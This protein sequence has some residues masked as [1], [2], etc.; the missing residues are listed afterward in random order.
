MESRTIPPPQAS[1]RQTE[2]GDAFDRVLF[3]ALDSLL[4]I[5]VPFALIGG[6]AAS[7]LGRP[8]STHDI[9]IFIRPD[10]AEA[11]IEA[12]ARGD[13]EVERTD[14]RWLFKGWKEGMMV[15]LIFKS[16]GDIYF[17]TE[18]HE[19]TRLIKYHGREIPTVSPEDF[20]IIKA[21]VHSEV[22][23]HHWHDALAVLSHAHVDWN[24]L[25]HRARRAPRRILA[26]LIY[27]QS[28]DIWIPNHVIIEL[29]QNIFGP[30]Q[31]KIQAPSQTSVA[32]SVASNG[33]PP[34]QPSTSSVGSAARSYAYLAGHIQERLAADARTGAADVQV[35]VGGRRIVVRGETTTHDHRHAIED[36]IRG[37]A[38]SL[39]VDFD[40]DFD[41]DFEIDNQ[42]RVTDVAGPEIER[43]Q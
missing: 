23:P 12:L 25:I 14:P 40:F 32:A 43:L 22:G 36:V 35:A 3:A 9:D 33:A 28:N 15:D 20:I 42:V 16:Q 6:I 2:M 10:D 11:A 27:A 30:V 38:R 29:H 21:A 31:T 8:R 1:A 18:M 39:A 13:F 7:G 41:F 5:S 24:Y 26:L 34:A 37:L 4:S 17:D 19:H